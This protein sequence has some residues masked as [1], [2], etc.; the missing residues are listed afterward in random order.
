MP[1]ITQC[2]TLSKKTQNGTQARKT[3]IDAKQQRTDARVP[4]AGAK[5]ERVGGNRVLPAEDKKTGEMSKQ[6]RHI[7]KSEDT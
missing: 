1:S 3:N 5:R 4:V 7:R 2:P 6:S